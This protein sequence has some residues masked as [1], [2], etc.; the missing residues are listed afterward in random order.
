MSSHSHDPFIGGHFDSPDDQAESPDQ[1]PDFESIAQNFF[2]IEPTLRD[3]NRHLRDLV[4]PCPLS[5][6]GDWIW[7]DE[8]GQAVVHGGLDGVRRLADQCRRASADID[9][10]MCDRQDVRD[11]ERTLWVSGRIG[12]TVSDPVSPHLPTGAQLRSRDN[13]GV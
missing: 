7:L 10:D 4:G 5:G 2:V 11:Q 8:A 9:D 6:D 12:N 1:G 13:R 3:A